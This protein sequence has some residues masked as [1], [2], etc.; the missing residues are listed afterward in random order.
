MK[1]LVTDSSVIDAL[2]YN[3]ELNILHVYFKATGK[4]T[5]G[6]VYGYYGVNKTVWADLCSASSLGE[7]FVHHIKNVYECKT[8]R[9]AR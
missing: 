3:T 8:I 5:V 7:Y 2:D 4:K 9:K 1:L 6:A